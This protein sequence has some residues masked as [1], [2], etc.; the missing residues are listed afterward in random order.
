MSTILEFVITAPLII[1]IVLGVLLALTA[2]FAVAFLMRAVR[3]MF[4]LSNLLIELRSI[5]DHRKQNLESTFQI[6]TTFSHLW[7]EYMDTLHH[8]HEY[9]PNGKLMAT[10]LRSTVPASIIFTNDVIVDTP[11]ATEFFRHLP[12]IFTGVGIIGTFWGLIVGLQAFQISDDPTV[13][14]QS[15]EAL[16][17]HVSSAFI[18]SAIAILLAMITTFVERSLVTVLYGKVEEI[19]ARLD[20]FFQSGASEEYLARLTKASEETSAQSQL[21]KDALVKDLERILTTLASSSTQ[22]SALVTRVRS[23]AVA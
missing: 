8:Q 21:L 17:H 9:E 15:L 3:M 4:I 14:R 11:L 22:T 12:G 10:I 2:I 13:V 7:K 5:N 18:V 23:T 1:Q 16:M 19:T 20:S 6:N